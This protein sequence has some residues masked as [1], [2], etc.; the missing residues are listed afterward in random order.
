MRYFNKWLMLSVIS[1][2][3]IGCNSSNITTTETNNNDN[4]NGNSDT[5]TQQ[6]IQQPV[7]WYMRVTVQSTDNNGKTYLHNTAGVFGELD[8][9]IDGLDKHDVIGAGRAI[10]QVRFVNSDFNNTGQYFSDYRQYN[11]SISSQRSWNV[12]VINSDK[13]VD[14]SNAPIKLDIQ[15]LKNIFRENNRYKEITSSSSDIRDS[16]HI[17]DLDNQTT[18][19]YAD[20]QNANLSMDDKHLRKF[21]IVLGEV[22]EN[23]MDTFSTNSI[24]PIYTTNSI[25]SSDKFGT[26]P[27]F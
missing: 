13:S 21:R 1:G 27:T 9:S 16:L 19:S 22:T 24:S 5:Q 12:V 10:L 2:I 4:D 14:L 6:S 11:G 20:L 17:I 8:E 3:V 15:N 26:P 25:N 23:D 7:G 18:Y